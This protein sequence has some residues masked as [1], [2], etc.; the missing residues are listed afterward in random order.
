M[1]FEDGEKPLIGDNDVYARTKILVGRKNVTIDPPKVSS[2]MTNE[3]W[4]IWKHT[5]TVS[6][7]AVV[8]ITTPCLRPLLT[9]S[10]FLFKSSDK[11]YGLF[12]RTIAHSLLPYDHNR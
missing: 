11:C 3:I 9:Y 6:C 7:H 5:K 12:T 1:K 8:W 4:W 10:K 2:I